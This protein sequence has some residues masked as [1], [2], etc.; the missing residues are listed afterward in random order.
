LTLHEPEL[1]SP[2]PRGAIGASIKRKEDRRLLRGRGQFVDDLKLPS[3]IYASVLRST[4]A[5]AK[6]R[7]IDTSRCA[8][9]S[10]VLAILTGD[11]VFRCTKPFIPWQ[12][13]KGTIRRFC[14]AIDKV[15]CVGDIV[16]VVAAEDRESAE[17]ALEVIDVEYEPLPA[18]VEIDDA[19]KENAA[20]VYEELGSNVLWSDSF[21]FG[22]VNKAFEDAEVVIQ[23]E[24]KM[25]RYTSVTL[26]TAACIADY[27]KSSGFL[28]IYTN[29][30][31]PGF[32]FETICNSLGIPGDKLRI[33]VQDVG[34][35]FGQKVNLPSYIFTSLLSMKTGRPVKWVETRSDNLTGPV[36]SAN[37]TFFVSFAM[38][39]D[40]V[41]NGIK[42][43]DYENE[44]AGLHYVSVHSLL[45]LSNMV[46]GYRVQNVGFE[47]HSIATNKCPTGANRGIGKPGMVF[48]IERMLDIAARR[49]KMSPIEI[50][51]RNFIPPEAFPYTTPTGNVYDSGNYPKSL[52]IAL[53]KIEYEKILEEQGRRN[54]SKSSN[55]IGIGIAFGI[56]PSTVNSS[57]RWLSGRKKLMLD[58]LKLPMTG[59]HGTASVKI[60]P[61]GKVIVKMGTPSN[62]QG[63]ETAAA[64]VVAEVLHLPIDDIEVLPAFD[65]LSTP[66][67]GYSG[68]LSNK[69]SDVDLGAVKGAAE[70]VRDKVLLIA[71]KCLDCDKEMLE[72][73][74][75][76]IYNA[77][78]PSHKISIKEISK[79][80]YYNV[81]LLPQGVEPTLEST[82]TYSNPWA[83]M[84]DELG[85][86]RMFNNFPYETHVAVI[87]VDCDTG[88]VRV[89]KYLV[90]S[91][92]GNMIN[93]MIVDGQIRG[94][95]LHGISA[96]L[97]EEFVYDS[98]GQLL[99]S[100]FV[101]YLKPTTMDAPSI[102]IA[103]LVTPSP[104]TPLGTKG[105]GEGGA[106][107]A[108]AAVTSAVE[109]ALSEF[110]IT[111]TELPLSPEKVLRLIKTA[112]EKKVATTRQN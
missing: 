34:G 49:L 50:R 1:L 70:R 89:C 8:E 78:E 95:T 55:K 33:I 39:K 79:L 43:V 97:H 105:V 4:Y 64:Q 57:Y 47:P 42:I 17:D 90:V 7:R 27:N 111:I 107:P 91:D 73:L 88:K 26:E 30:Q 9:N 19:L 63:H 69:F 61:T 84:P 24:F 46:N 58:A 40:G 62:G 14:L 108:P 71:A 106:I 31:F 82:F 94:A 6:I 83:N 51:L 98:T 29:D 96:A 99:S 22:E 101:D 109:N 103:H 52:K 104:F 59:S 67:G 86:V 15:R 41:I 2:I 112:K 48:M 10:R 32:F 53:D 93:P 81:L 28:T 72:L 3:M 56:E 23:Q 44:G 45:K 68:V 11:E 38:K 54:S 18:V 35:G 110:G 13:N 77:R 12:S 65:T 36:Q 5:H 25:H 75:G 66:W 21:S 87:E 60:D 37:G 100:N 80:A 16:A 85:R 102:E 92:C 76:D 74:N 20:L